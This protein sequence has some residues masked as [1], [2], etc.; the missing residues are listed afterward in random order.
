[1]KL[2]YF[3]WCLLNYK[4]HWVASQVCMN[5]TLHAIHCSLYFDKPKDK[6]NFLNTFRTMPCVLFWNRHQNVDKR[7]RMFVFDLCV[8]NRI[9]YKFFKWK[10]WSQF[11]DGKPPIMGS[12]FRYTQH[13]STTNPPVIYATDRSKAVVPVLF[14]SCVALWFMLRGASCCLTLCSRVCQ[15]F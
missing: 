6:G 3:F 9:V 1:M 14:L 11:I 2:T 8:E 7:P 5:P 12:S 15:S 4:R 13:I 10:S